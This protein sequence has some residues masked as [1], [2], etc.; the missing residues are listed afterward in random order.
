M[1]WIST[2][3]AA[4]RENSDR[5]AGQTVFLVGVAASLMLVIGL[6][7]DGGGKL[8][9]IEHANSAA[10]QA[11]RIA[12]QHLSA[13]GAQSGGGAVTDRSSATAAA[14]Q[15]LSAQGVD[16]TVAI[17]GGQVTVTTTATYDTIFLPIIGITSLTGTGQATARIA[18]GITTESG[19]SVP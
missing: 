9:A 6:V 18:E 8:N 4:L 15:A 16:G 13:G 3:I 11:A 7:V 2:R 19:G 17:S 12:G 14:E 1:S 5:G 10:Q